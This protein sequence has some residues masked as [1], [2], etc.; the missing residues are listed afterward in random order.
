M[1]NEIM[2]AV[3]RKLDGL[4]PDCRIYTDE[5]EQGLE[6]PCFFVA[7][8]EPSEKPVI[9]RRCFRQTGM[10]IQYLPGENPEISREFNRVSDLLMDGLEYVTLEDGCLI[11][12]T[13]RSARPD[14]AEKV[15]TFLVSYNLFTM[16]SGTVEDEMEQMEADIRKG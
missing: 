10:T 5:T 14:V 6:E 4:F 16:K 8:L 7:F 1:L 13:G 11:R 12:G 2:D 9:G 15:L 3:T